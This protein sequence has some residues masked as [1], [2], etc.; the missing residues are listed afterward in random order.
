MAGEEND[1]KQ[2]V[3]VYPIMHFII[4]GKGF[5]EKKHVSHKQVWSEYHNKIG[6]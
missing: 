2:G 1:P 3:N 5:S 6:L 4:L